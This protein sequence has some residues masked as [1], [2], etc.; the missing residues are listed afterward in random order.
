MIK[1]SISEMINA[2]IHFGHQSK[3][4]NPKMKP[5]IYM[6]YNK[7]H[8]INLNKTIELLNKSLYEILQL[9]KKKK[10]ILFVGTKR[11]A[12]KLIKKTA[13]KCN[14]YFVNHRWLGGMLTNWKTVK[15]SIKHFKN[16]EKKFKNKKFN[17]LTKKEFIL[18]KRKFNKLK[19]NLEGIKNMNNIPDAIFIIDAKHEKIAIKEA[20]Q[21]KIKIFAI[22]DSNSNPEGIDYIIPGNDDSKRSIKWYLHQINKINNKKN[23]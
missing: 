4:W 18:K 16:T 7:I 2:S 6:K 1:F 10:K 21:L 22:I 12:R 23:K 13:L 11:V 17:K 15:K 20:R 19:K 8:I 14:Q 5:Y 3:Y 9:Q